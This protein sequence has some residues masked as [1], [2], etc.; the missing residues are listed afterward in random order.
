MPKKAV[1]RKKTQ[2]ME[3]VITA[4]VAEVVHAVE[5]VITPGKR[6]L[7]RKHIIYISIA[8]LFVLAALPSL[9]FY[10]QYQQ[11]QKLLNSPTNASAEQV[12]QL[13]T[14]INTH[15]VL[16]E[17]EVPTVATVSDKT[18][19]ASQAFF[20]KAENGD[21]VLIYSSTRKAILYRPSLDKIIEMGPVSLSADANAQTPAVAGAS[22]EVTPTPTPAPVKVAIYNGTKTVG[23]A[24]KIESQ[25][26][27]KNIAIEVVNKDNA[28]AEY[29][30]T[31]IIDLTRGSKTST[32]SQIT[33]VIK[34]QI[35]QAVPQKENKPSADILI[36]LGK[37]ISN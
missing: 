9:Y 19:L 4:P 16:P 6:S 21:K 27:A 12:K 34:A 23:L 30:K 37:D 5:E 29:E 15:I 28:S 1:H 8:G 10:S 26:L 31:Q 11:S 3:E 7:A 13:I 25:L 18:K 35:Q 24:K 2:V 32:I 17:G 36:I 14:K 33:N 20:A 22:T